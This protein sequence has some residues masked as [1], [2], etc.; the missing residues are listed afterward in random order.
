MVLSLG[1]LCLVEQAL[2]KEIAKAEVRGRGPKLRLLTS[3]E[4]VTMQTSGD[5][6]GLK[7]RNS[8][9][10]EQA[11]PKEIAKG[12]VRGRGQKCGDR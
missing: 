2:P 3:A 1:T 9:F 5:K 4:T 6:N 12:E 8:L 11:L 7:L 10:G